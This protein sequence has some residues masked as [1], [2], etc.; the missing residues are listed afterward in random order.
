MHEMSVQDAVDKYR[1]LVDDLT[2]VVPTFVNVTDSLSDLASALELKAS[3]LEE[4]LEQDIRQEE[5][6]VQD[7]IQ[8]LHDKIDELKAD[9]KQKEDE[10]N[11]LRKRVVAAIESMDELVENRMKDLKKEL[12]QVQR[13]TLSNDAIKNLAPLTLLHVRSWVATYST[14]Q[15]KLFV[16][17]MTPED[18]FGL[19]LSPQPL[20]EKFG[21]FL[22]KLYKRILKDSASFSTSLNSLCGETNVLQ[23]PSSVALFTKG[24]DRLRDRQLLGEDVREKVEPKYSSLAGRCPECNAEIPPNAKFCNECG[25]SLA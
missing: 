1:S 17:M 25:K 15:P 11:K 8:D 19:P 22:D 4:K 6:S 3:D 21:S 18:R 10:F 14:G 16:P 12:E 24:M 2:T 9:I 13:M 7:Q 5:D 20:D 23:D